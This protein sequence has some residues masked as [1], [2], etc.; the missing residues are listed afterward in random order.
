MTFGH[1]VDAETL[2]HIGPQH[3]EAD[4]SNPDGSLAWFLEGGGPLA[5]PVVAS[6]GPG[7]VRHSA[8]P[9]CG[10][11]PSRALSSL[12]HFGFHTI[13]ATWGCGAMSILARLSRNKE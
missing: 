3:F 11:R 5:A 13:W 1:D 8:L 9:R 4:V 10:G 7:L 2:F 6:F 12:G